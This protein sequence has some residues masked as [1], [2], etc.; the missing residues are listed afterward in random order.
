MAF[1]NMPSA[2]DHIY[3]GKLRPI[4]VTTAKRWAGAPDIRTIAESG[5]SGYEVSVWFGLLAPAGTPPAVVDAL[6]RA[7]S[8]VTRQ[9]NVEKRLLDLGREFVG[10]TP[11]SFAQHVADEIAK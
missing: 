3:S 6:H 5:V 10:N 1:D 2:I 11:A 9:P 4:A 7:V 8:T